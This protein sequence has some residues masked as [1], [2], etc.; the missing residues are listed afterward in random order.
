MKAKLHLFLIISILAVQISLA[1]DIPYKAEFLKNITPKTY[2]EL[3]EQTYP[4]IANRNLT[5]NFSTADI[6]NKDKTPLLQSIK[7]HK[8][9][10][11]D[12]INILKNKLKNDFT[13]AETEFEIGKQFYELQNDSFKIYMNNAYNYCN[14]G[15][16]NQPDS[17]SY[18]LLKAKIFDFYG[19]PELTKEVYEL[20]MKNIPDE[21]TS[22]M[23]LSMFYMQNGQSDEAEKIIRQGIEH[24]PD[25]EIFYFNLVLNN[26]FKMAYS[27]DNESDKYLSETPVNI[28][29]GI[30]EFA[31]AAQKYKKNTDFQT[32]FHATEVFIIF[33]KNLQAAG[34]VENMMS[35]KTNPEV[36]E[37]IKSLNAYFEKSLK[38]KKK[39]NAYFLYY[40]LG[41]LKIAEGNFPEAITLLENA[42]TDRL[43]YADVETSSQN[44]IYN[45]LAACYILSGDTINAVKTLNEK[46]A[47]FPAS[48]NYNLLAYTYLIDNKNQNAKDLL[49]SAI[50]KG[51]F[52]LQTVKALAIVHLLE[53]DI[54]QADEYLAEISRAKVVD[55][56]TYIIAGI[57]EVMKN[58]AE[59]AWKYFNQ[60]QQMNPANENLNDFLDLIFVKQ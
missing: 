23:M 8:P 25:N 59:T 1:Q 49:L 10:S 60:A 7:T 17:V 34:N 44:D 36:S 45:N 24:F 35:Y 50:N 9:A 42:K 38:S 51:I 16:E 40:A 22:Y 33:F 52:D 39:N 20:M 29:F 58:N 6:Q 37:K 30:D 48:E 5:F 31:K 12:S 43:K 54:T 13:D 11:R 47:F 19:K 4:F 27:P 55:Y 14:E 15:I 56:E 57:M 28:M 46:L 2:T 53:N 18:Y 21:T 3:L 32:T 41:A 26:F